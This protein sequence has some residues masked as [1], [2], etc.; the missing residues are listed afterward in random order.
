MRAPDGLRGLTTDS[1][2]NIIMSASKTANSWCRASFSLALKHGIYRDRIEL[3]FPDNRN[4]SNV[5]HGS[6]AV[7]S[8]IRRK[9]TSPK[10]H[11]C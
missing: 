2:S 7:T 11:A 10:S 9:P 5:Y 8:D 3:A 4:V 6:F 1:R